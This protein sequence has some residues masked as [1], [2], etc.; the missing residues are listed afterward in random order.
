[1]TADAASFPALTASPPERL[2]LARGIALVRCDPERT[3]AVVAAIN[4]S[5]DH[6]RPWMAW[7]SEPATATSIGT[8]LAA[9]AE[10]WDQRRDFG[11]SILDTTTDAVVGG[12]GLH[13]R[14]GPGALEIGYWVHVD[15]AGQGLATL[16]A[17][18]LTGAAFDLDGIQRVEIHCEAGNHRSARV[19]EKL[20]YTFE[21]LVVP[22]GGPCAGRSTQIWTITEPV[23]R[24]LTS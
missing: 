13:N 19:P 7:A 10:L 5:L 9:Q 2:D 3:D 1:V 15:R 18:A 12:T 21:G 8:F 24:A 6:L 4:A 11:Y 14:L 20:G 17:T 16:V 22:E 23:W